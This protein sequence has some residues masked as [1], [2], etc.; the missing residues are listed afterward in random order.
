MTADLI[1]IQ[2]R[3]DVALLSEQRIAAVAEQIQVERLVGLPL[4]VAFDL[5]GD[6]FGRLAWEKG[7]RPG[8]GDVVHAGDG[9]AVRGVERHRHELVLPGDQSPGGVPSSPKINP[10]VQPE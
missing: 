5:D 6:G 8:L 9:C 3:A 10:S 4:A 1:L 2:Y 7:D